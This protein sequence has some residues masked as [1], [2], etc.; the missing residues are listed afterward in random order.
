MSK[1]EHM[2][3]IRFTDEEF[4]A[5][6]A[7]YQR[8]LR[9]VLAGVHFGMSDMLR[10]KALAPITSQRNQNPSLYDNAIRRKSA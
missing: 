3:S 6:N 9:E 4:D 7:E 1:R 5:L 10:S 2:I 8:K